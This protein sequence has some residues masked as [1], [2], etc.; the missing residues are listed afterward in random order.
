[1]CR[2]RCSDA[3][4][5]LNKTHWKTAV[6]ILLTLFYIG[7]SVYTERVLAQQNLVFPAFCCVVRV[8]GF[9]AHWDGKN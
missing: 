7:I 9:R 4:Y 1:M 8:V 6:I 2:P 5:V 3:L